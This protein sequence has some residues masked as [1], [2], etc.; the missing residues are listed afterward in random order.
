MPNCGPPT[1]PSELCSYIVE[2]AI[3]F[4]DSEEFHEDWD[5]DCKEFSELFVLGCSS[6]GRF[7]SR[8]VR[9]AIERPERRVALKLTIDSA[10]EVIETLCLVK[11]EY[12]DTCVTTGLF[13]ALDDV[14]T[15]EIWSTICSQLRPASRAKWDYFI[16]GVSKRRF[17]PDLVVD[18]NG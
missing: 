17:S 2:N 1:R 7:A 6:L 18:L 14:P 5:G 11:D 4:K 13:E 15:E 3:G 16:P 8:I 9:E 10:F 12:I